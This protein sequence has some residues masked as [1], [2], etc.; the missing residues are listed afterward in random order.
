M[1]FLLIFLC[2]SNCLMFSG[3]QLT[4]Q[5]N[6]LSSWSLNSS[7]GAN[8]LNAGKIITDK[9]MKEVRS[10]HMAWAIPDF[11][12][13]TMRLLPFSVCV[14][15]CVCPSLS[16]CLSLINPYSVEALCFFD[17]L[18]YLFLFKTI[19]FLLT[20]LSWILISCTL[21]LE[22]SGSSGWFMPLPYLLHISPL[23]AP[24]TLSFASMIA[25]PPLRAG[26][27]S[28]LFVTLSASQTHTPPPA[29]PSPPPP[30]PMS[31]LPTLPSLCL[32][33]SRNSPE[34]VW[35]ELFIHQQLTFYN[36]SAVV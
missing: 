26:A 33:Q 31:Q 7:D 25:F 14:C 21:I 6:W 28:L 3:E 22:P 11:G 32:V 17:H 30:L 13:F 1:F 35:V 20:H 36:A 24:A 2:A 4:N 29:P 9:N 15:V 16:F 23:S 12:S 18:Q 19:H 8:I 27:G 34:M 5:T 10:L